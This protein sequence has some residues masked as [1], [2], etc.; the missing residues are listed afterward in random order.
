M[1]REARERKWQAAVAVDDRLQGRVRIIPLDI[2]DPEVIRER[3][4]AYLEALGMSAQESAPWVACATEGAAYGGQAFVRL[5]ELM[6]THAAGGADEVARAARFRLALWT[7]MPE[8]AL[9]AFLSV[10]PL[11]RQPMAPERDR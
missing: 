3:L 7:G 2:S 1:T 6:A 9:A 10:L 8:T 5:Q 11:C 4:T